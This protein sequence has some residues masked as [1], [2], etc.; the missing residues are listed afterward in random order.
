MILYYAS[1]LRLV[2]SK[3]LDGLGLGYLMPCE[4][5]S[6]G[7][8]GG[9]DGENGAVFV[10]T[11][12]SLVESLAGRVGYYPDK[13]TWVNVAGI[14]CGKWNDEPVL[15][16]WL[17]RV[18]QR[19]GYVIAMGGADW[20][21][22]VARTVDGKT[23]LLREHGFDKDGEFVTR[24]DSRYQG[25]FD[26]ACEVFE[27]CMENPTDW[28]PEYDM[29]AD[30]VMDALSVNYRIWKPEIELLKMFDSDALRQGVRAVIDWYQ[31][32]QVAVLLAARKKA[33]ESERSEKSDCCDS[34][35]EHG[36]GCAAT[37]TSGTPA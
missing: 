27:H 22:P 6:R 24:I 34:D 4:I 7:C 31:A 3:D 37:G 36:A 13:Q 28:M 32:E 8:T 23:H 30:L 35:T 12:N 17:A 25:L 2:A 1:G 26:R 10:A 19:R 21:V 29:V 14:W 5:Q 33:A 16:L 20:L 9:P 15:S 11:N 18:E